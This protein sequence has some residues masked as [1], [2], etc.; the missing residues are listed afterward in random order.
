MEVHC[1]GGIGL[2]HP[3][4]RQMLAKPFRHLCLG[5]HHYVIIEHSTHIHNA[6]NPTVDAID[7]QL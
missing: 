6:V 2:L 1:C 5:G 3:N 7:R 4:E